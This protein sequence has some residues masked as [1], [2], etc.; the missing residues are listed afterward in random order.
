MVDPFAVAQHVHGCKF[1]LFMTDSC[2]AENS[3][4]FFGRLIIFLVRPAGLVK[5]FCAVS[6]LQFFTLLHN[7]ESAVDAHFH[8]SGR[9]DCDRFLDPHWRIPS[10]NSFL[11]FFLSHGCVSPYFLRYRTLKIFV[12][13]GFFIFFSSS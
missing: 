5:H 1:C 3:C 7:V 6:M 2:A 8:T 11:L 13:G 9:S 12:V 10:V 4:V